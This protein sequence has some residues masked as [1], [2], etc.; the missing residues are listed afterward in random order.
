MKQ[1][2]SQRK[3]IRF[4]IFSFLASALLFP[5]GYSQTTSTLNFP[6]GTGINIGLGSDVCADEVIINGTYNGGGTICDGALPVTMLYFT[7]KI[8]DENSVKLEWSTSSELNNSGFQVERLRVNNSGNEEWILAKFVPGAG[9]TNEPRIYNYNEVGMHK[10]TYKYRLKQIDFNANFEY[11]SL[12]EE[13]IIAAPKKFHLSQNFPNPSNPTSKINFQIP[14]NAHVT[15]KIFN[16][17]GEEVN[18]LLNEEREAGFY[19]VEFNGSSMASGVYLYRLS[20]VNSENTFTKT[21]KLIL[22][23]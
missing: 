12:N 15:I 8:E 11:F 19:S 5:S 3:L 4:I 1:N 7:G 9:T 10:G 2:H 23:K 14:E 22:V 20:S 17:I 18:T 21:M 6:G 13:L 16:L